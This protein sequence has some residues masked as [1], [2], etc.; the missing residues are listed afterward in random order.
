R[1]GHGLVDAPQGAAGGPSLFVGEAAPAFAVESASTLAGPGR[2]R[3]G[4]AAAC[5]YSGPG[6]LP[7]RGGGGWLPLLH[8]AGIPLANPSQKARRRAY[9]GY[10]P[11]RVWVAHLADRP[12]E[13]AATKIE[14]LTKDDVWYGDP[15]WSPDDKVIVVHANRTA[16]RESVRYSINRN[17][18]LFA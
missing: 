17:F 14:R 18:D 4:A 10:R 1:L 12:G 15:Q 3:R 5:C 11:A 7:G 8:P 16:D 6:S 2:N 13:H 9:T